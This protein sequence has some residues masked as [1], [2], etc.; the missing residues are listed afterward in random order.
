M[1]V[2]LC[3]AAESEYQVF[4]DKYIYEKCGEDVLKREATKSFCTFSDEANSSGLKEFFKKVQDKFYELHP[5]LIGTKP[6]TDNDDIK[7]RF[8]PFDASPEKRKARTDGAKELLEQLKSLTITKAKLKTREARALASLEY[9]LKHNFDF[10]LEHYDKGLWLLGPDYLCNHI[11]CDIGTHLKI[12]AR[13]FEPRSQADV[14][15][16]I[17]WIRGFESTFQQLK[18]NLRLG[19]KAGMVQPKDVCKASIDALEQQYPGLL[20]NGP[21]GV[22]DEVFGEIL[23]T[24]SFT[25]GLPISEHDKWRQKYNKMMDESLKEALVDGF[26]KPWQDY[27]D[28]L[29][30][31]HLQHCV[32]S[33]V[34]SGL[35]MLPLDYVYVDGKANK[36]KRTTK[37]L[38]DGTKLN[39]S[40]IYEQII[41]YYATTDLPVDELY[42]RG[43]TVL[44]KYYTKM[45]RLA[46][47]ISQE[48]DPEEAIK[49]FKEIGSD[50]K[51][52]FNEGPFPDEENGS[53][54]QKKCANPK[55]AEKNCPKR[56]KALKKWFEFS[57]ETMKNI[58]K[59]L[60]DLFYQSGPK[61]SVPQCQITLVPDFNP[62]AGVPSYI[63]GDD[64]CMETG[65]YF[66]PF[67]NEKNGPSYEDTTTNGHEAR[68]GHHLQSQGFVENFADTCDDEITWLD[69][70]VSHNTAF[71]EG[72]GLYAENPLLSDDL[73]MYEHDK[74]GELGMTKWQ[75]WRALRVIV[76]IGL[77][78]KKMTRE[79]ALSLFEK[80]A[81]DSTDMVKKEITRYQGT[82]GQATS[83]LIGQQVIIDARRN[84][85]KK[86]GRKFDLKEFHFQ[87]LSQGHATLDFIKTYMGHHANCESGTAEGSCDH[88]MSKEEYS[89]FCR[90]TL[91]R[92]EKQNIYSEINYYLKK[93]IYY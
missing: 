30:N 54:A 44:N 31:E 33:K 57:K 91:P 58:S 87:I 7:R 88:V 40:K 10:P 82:P 61:R 70:M 73:D 29:K 83:Y 11:S 90:R 27:V 23:L 48:N 14:E 43:K 50:Q 9:F 41:H 6:D 93:R 69:D 39:G 92:T 38:P 52:Y 72:W 20:D 22:T 68:P 85:E 45:E 18:E 2:K 53:E 86:L 12:L 76:D 65:K 62:S 8:R 13:R 15:Q 47:E 24:G 17:T 60:P 37:Q 59:K 3:L 19:V 42:S 36:E 4:P 67:F 79:K 32:S 89:H 55:R 56:W 84:A 64:H 81:W 71:A 25:K 77:H 28:Y 35:S 34:A 80:Y 26:G 74:M 21:N 75:V 66:I 49:K 78:Y 5:F 46:K 63:E 16:M 1:F 51:Y